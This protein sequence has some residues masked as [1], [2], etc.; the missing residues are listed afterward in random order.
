[1]VVFIWRSHSMLEGTKWP[2]QCVNH[3]SNLPNS[4]LSISFLPLSSWH[5]ECGACPFHVTPGPMSLVHFVLMCIILPM[6][7]WNWLKS[8]LWWCPVLGDGRRFP[9][10]WLIGLILWLKFQ[11]DSLVWFCVWRSRVNEC[12]IWPRGERPIDIWF[13]WDW[14]RSSWCSRLSCPSY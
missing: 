10:I 1:M 14:L 2:R 11:T 8:Y 7:R 9:E 4:L 3:L 12:L 13:H 5:W 6:L